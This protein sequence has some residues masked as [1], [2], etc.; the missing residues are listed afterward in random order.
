MSWYNKLFLVLM[1]CGVAM[2]VPAADHAQ[3]TPLL[4]TEL[5]DLPGKEVAMITVSYAPGASDSAHRHNAH[6]FVYVLE[7][8]VVMQVKGGKEFTIGPGQTFYESPA[9]VHTVSRNASRTE[10][11]KFLVFFLKQKGAPA[12]VPGTP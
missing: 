4:S 12:L 11:A 8:S 10:P 1:V 2:P 3:V 9:D 5:P 6:T 7:G